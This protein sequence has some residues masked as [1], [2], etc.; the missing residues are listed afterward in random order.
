MFYQF[1][2]KKEV[3][4]KTA[5]LDIHYISELIWINLNAAAKL[6]RAPESYETYC[7][8][9]SSE[10]IPQSYR[11]HH[12]SAVNAWNSSSEMLSQRSSESYRY[13]QWLS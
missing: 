1:T 13:V 9:Y 5:P 6:S 8:Q 7:C 2:L 11:K 4:V 10:E 3:E 12:P